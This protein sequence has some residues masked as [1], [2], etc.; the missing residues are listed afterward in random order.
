MLA[1]L[2]HFVDIYKIDTLLQSQTFS[3]N[4]HTTN[5][6]LVILQTLTSFLAKFR[7]LFDYF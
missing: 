7:S 1:N 5:T 4:S 2:Q 6:T 3:N